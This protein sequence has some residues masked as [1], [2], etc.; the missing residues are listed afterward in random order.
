MQTIYYIAAIIFSFIGIVLGVGKLMAAFLPIIREFRTKQILDK[1]FSQGPYDEATIQNS[2]R[3][4]IHPK[5]SNIDP[6][7]EQEMRSALIA[8]R[9]DL[10]INIDKFLDEDNSYRH[11]L[12]L[13]DSGT[14]KTSFMLNY[15]AY[16]YTQRTKRKRQ[17]LYIVPLGIPNADALIEKCE[18]KP[19]TSILLDAFDEDTK[20][21]SDHHKR[22]NNLMASCQSFKRVIITSRTQFFPMDEEIPTET[23]IARIGPRSAGV[24][25]TYEFCKVYLSPFD[26]YEVIRYLKKRFPIW[27]YNLRKRAIEYVLKIPMLSVRPMLLAH[28]PF[29][30]S[31]NRNINNS[32]ELYEIMIDAWLDRET[33]RDKENKTSLRKFSELLAVNIYCNREERGMEQVLPDELSELSAKWGF[34]ISQRKLTGASLLNRDAKGHYKFAHRSIMEYF[35]VISLIKGDDQCYRIL[36]TDQMKKFIMELFCVTTTSLLREYLKVDLMACGVASIESIY[37]RQNT[38]FKGV[39][40]VLINTRFITNLKLE[41]KKN[42]LYQINSEIRKNGIYFHP[43]LIPNGYH[44]LL[45]EPIK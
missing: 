22:M 5:C 17:K 23:G 4:Y 27:R 35:F 6:A 26:D 40:D 37:N 39:E 32:S 19:N 43:P 10:F 2:T 38:E 18:D 36:L 30:V 44:Y 13:G 45:F 34:S 12:L 42:E 16:N 25:L 28:I 11:L 41:Q 21:I 14:G 33:T 8:T 3:Y 24:K 7:R 15:Y 31:S 29:I 1:K 20:A 9:E